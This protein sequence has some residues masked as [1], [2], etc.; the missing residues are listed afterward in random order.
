MKIVKQAR[1]IIEI[2]DK[3]N[4]SYIHSM[5]TKTSILNRILK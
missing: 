2:G 3:K 1:R 5:G 4:S